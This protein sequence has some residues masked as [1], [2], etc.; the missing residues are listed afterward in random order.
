MPDDPL[1]SWRDHFP[2]LETNTYL[3]SNSLGAMPRA[4]EHELGRYTSLWGRRGVRAWAEEWW[5]LGSR[6]ADLVAPLLGAPRGSI[7]MHPNTTLATAVMLSCLSPART[8]RKVITTDLHFPS[9]LYLL[10]GWCRSHDATLQTV[11][12]YGAWGADPQRLLDSIDETTLA[13]CLSHVEYATAWVNDAPALAKRCR[14]A[15]AFLILDIF[16]SAGTLPLDLQGWGVDAAVGGCLKWLC[17]GPGNVFLYVDPEL[18]DT[19][20]PWLTGWAAHRAPFSFTP[21]PIEHSSGAERFLNGT[22]Q[23]SALY[24]ARPGLEILGQVGIDAVRRKSLSLCGKIVEGSTARNFELS[25]PT[26]PACRGGTIALDVPDA[27]LVAQELLTRNVVIDYRPGF[28][29][30]IAPHFYSTWEECE[31]CLDTIQ[32]V[33]ETRSFERHR[34]VAGTKP[35]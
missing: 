33:L 19:L 27:E 22:P 14:E 6:V 9:I 30:R 25:S 10:E 20:Q 18:S 11:P 13:V 4:V 35:T 5:E 34:S 31:L 21:P 26:D 15:G 24:C 3:I 16:Q 23:V 28:G 12:R 32:E 7:S 1:L 29:I 2:V 8:R 17:G